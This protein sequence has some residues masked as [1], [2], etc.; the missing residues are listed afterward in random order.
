MAEQQNIAELGLVASLAMAQ[1]EIKNAP[2]NKTNPGYKSKYADLASIRDQVV[3]VLS[4]FGIAVI[5]VVVERGTG[6]SVVTKLLKGDEELTSEC[7]IMVGEKAT[8]QSFGSAMTYAKRYG[9]AAIVCIAAGEDD[10]GNAAQKS[11]DIQ[12]R[13]RRK[14]QQ[15]PPIKESQ[16]TAP[17]V[18]VPV[19]DDGEVNWIGFYNNFLSKLNEAQSNQDIDDLARSCTG[20]FKNLKQHDEGLFTDLGAKVTKKREE[21]ANVQ[22]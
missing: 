18:E 5:Q 6:F 19:S 9:L 12:T 3:P 10:D 14:V 8:P 22:P 20:A 7:P 2:L 15:S 1:Q 16:K 13:A 21:V 11:G 17:I 4:R